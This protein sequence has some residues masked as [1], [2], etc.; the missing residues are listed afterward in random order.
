MNPDEVSASA[1]VALVIVTG[2]LAIATFAL[3]AIAA[4][5]DRIR[6]WLVHPRLHMSVTLAPPDCVKT[7]FSV[8]GWWS[9]VPLTH[10]ECYYLRMRVHN[11][12]GN[13]R[14]EHVEVYASVLSRQQAD[15]SF[16]LVPS[17]L[18][19]NL[20]WSHVRLMYLDAISPG[21]EHLCDIGHVFNPSI[22]ATATPTVKLPSEITDGQAGSLVL[23][24]QAPPLTMSHVLAP[25]K[26]RLEIMIGAANSNPIKK[27]L[28]ISVTGRW[29]DDQ[30]TMLGEGVGL[31]IV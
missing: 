4:F 12:E 26:Y 9:G 24:V 28:E 29:F 11:N 16:R 14:A 21:M 7:T 10:Y 5:Q 13:E 20:L 6:A 31:R 18:P 19:M 23:D 17:F 27:T 1:A 3:A 15:G 8:G 22:R 2:L 30:A 25:G